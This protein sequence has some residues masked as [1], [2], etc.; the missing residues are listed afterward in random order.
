MSSRIS[1][2]DPLD[3]LI[4]TTGLWFLAKFL[5]YT[6]PPL[7]EPFQGFYEVSSTELGLAFSAFMITYAA[8]QFPSGVLRDR[9]GPVIVVGTGGTI[10]GLASLS[11][12]VDG[13]FL[14][15]V[16][17]MV[18]IGLGT[19]LHKTVS[20]TLLA[21]VYP[22]RTGRVLGIHD[23]FGTSAGFIA[24][25]VAVFAVESIG[26]RIVFVI[27]GIAGLVLAG[28]A[29]VRLPSRLPDGIK[30]AADGRTKQSARDYASLFANRTFSVFLLLTIGVAFAYNGAVAF[31][32]MYLSDVAG[33][34][35]G[36][37]GAFY[38][39]LFAVSIVQVAT[40]EL[41][42]RTGRLSMIVVLLAI[43]TLGIATLLVA[44]GAILV[45]VAVVLI[46]VGAHGFRPVRDAY[47]T[48]LLPDDIV[49]GGLGIAR[50]LLMGAGAIAP[51]IV[52]WSAETFSFPVAFTLLLIAM[53]LAAV[54]GLAIFLS[55]RMSSV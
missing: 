51:A 42:D 34:S 43:A 22:T 44:Q 50:S 27:G 35:V 23:T 8:M 4:I 32:P 5:R 16:T 48:S 40:G 18:F 39:L 2:R 55:E 9:L 38:S 1:S 54:A 37:A 21:G 28:S 25:I 31:L 53:A 19:G 30:D 26:W 49:G 36:L 41:S 33:M 17:A 10:A 15:V 47:L 11:L 20:V 7:F 12:V 52:G 3:V 45:A 24:P 6:F 46:G 29:F 13:G 14:L